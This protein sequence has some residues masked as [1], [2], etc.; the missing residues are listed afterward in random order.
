MYGRTCK[1]YIFRSSNFYF[2]RC[3]VFLINL[4][5]V[6]TTRRTKKAKEFKISRYYWLFSSEIMAVKGLNNLQVSV[7]HIIGIWL[8]LLKDDGQRASRTTGTV[9]FCFLFFVFLSRCVGYVY[10]LTKRTSFDNRDILWHQGCSLTVAVSV[11]VDEDEDSSA[12]VVSVAVVVFMVVVA[13]RHPP[14]F[15]HIFG[16]Y[17]YT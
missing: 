17:M 15:I 1:Q 2:Q 11:L 16:I 13:T 5:H 10:P 12:V 14:A 7:T 4:S 6:S 3:G 8:Y 9:G